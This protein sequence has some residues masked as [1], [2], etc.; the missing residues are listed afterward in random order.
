[1]VIKKTPNP[2]ETK[3]VTGTT[4]TLLSQLILKN[5]IQYLMLKISRQV[6]I[7]ILLFFNHLYVT[8]IQH[9]GPEQYF[10]FHK[11]SSEL[12]EAGSTA[13]ADTEFCLFSS[14][15]SKMHPARLENSVSNT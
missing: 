13:K 15:E 8:V 5:F 6:L 10:L 14:E 7:I 2:D 12:T 1:M 9:L 3:S 11:S 4:A